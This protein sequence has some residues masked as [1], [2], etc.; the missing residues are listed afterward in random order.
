MARNY[1]TPSTQKRNTWRAPCL[2]MMG[3]AVQS[4]LKWGR[5]CTNNLVSKTFEVAMPAKLPIWNQSM[6]IWTTSCKHYSCILHEMNL[7]VLIHVPCL[8]HKNIPL[9]MTFL[10][11]N[12][13]KDIKGR[14]RHRKQTSFESLKHVTDE[15]H[16]RTDSQGQ[17]EG[18]VAGMGPCKSCNCSRS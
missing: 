15:Q 11:G 2:Y 13:S 16:G 4:L 6:H 3:S 17:W 18:N 7:S 12:F 8:H 9:K 5:N 1:I 10:V 14:R